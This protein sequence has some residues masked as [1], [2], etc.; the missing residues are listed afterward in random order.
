M[1]AVLRT[2][3]FE[4][5]TLVGFGSP[6]LAVGRVVHR[7]SAPLKYCR[8]RDGRQSARGG[9][10][11]DVSYQTAPRRARALRSAA[12]SG[13]IAVVSTPPRKIMRIVVG[14]IPIESDLGVP[15]LSQNRQF[16]WFSKPTYVYPM[17]PASAATLRIVSGTSSTIM[18]TRLPMS[19]MEDEMNCGIV[20][21]MTCRRV[22]TS[23]V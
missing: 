14:Y 11:W 5:G 12:G 17:V 18:A 16:Q 4:V 9:S 10:G 23:L 8:S 7:H 20:W 3:R 19:E 1:P 13:R 2:Q 6:N 21:L 22:S 15:L